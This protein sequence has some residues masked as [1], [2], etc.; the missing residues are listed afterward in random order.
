MLSG[1]L[2][3]MRLAAYLVLAD[4]LVPEPLVKDFIFKRSGASHNALL[5]VR[6]GGGVLHNLNHTYNK[7][8]GSINVTE[9]STHLF[10]AAV[11]LNNRPILFPVE[12][13][14]YG[15]RQRSSDSVSQMDSM[16]SRI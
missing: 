13:Q 8:E 7:A 1:A 10:P 2:D 9:C 15:N 12:M 14:P 5:D 3:L 11:Q 16:I 6:D 4:T